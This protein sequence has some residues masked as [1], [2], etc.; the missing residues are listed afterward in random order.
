[1]SS[2][3]LAGPS[4]PLR[5]T[6]TEARRCVNWI[7]I[8]IESGTGKGGATTALKQLAGLT[9][10]GNYGAAIRALKVTRGRLFAVTDGQLSEVD[11][12]W[13]STP[14]GSIT[15][16]Q[17]EIDAN[18]T[19]V[20]IVNGDSLFVFDLDANTLS[21]NPPNW[22][23]SA[24][25]SVLDG[26]GLFFAPGTEQFYISAVEDFTS[27]DALDFATA[28]S[29]TGN[30][31]G[32]LAK[33][34]EV[35]ILKELGGE[36]WDD[37][38]GSDFPLSRNESAVIEIGLAA[39]ATLRKVASTAI[40]LGQDEDGNGIVFGMPGYVPQRISSQAL[41]EKLAALEDLSG[42]RAWT[43]H[44]EGLSFYV[45]NVPGLETTWCYEVS[46]GIWDERGEWLDGAWQPWRATCHALAFGQHVVGDAAGNLYRLDP[47]VNNNAGDPLVRDWISPHEAGPNL[48]VQRFGSFEV[49]GDVGYGL[50]DTTA[51]TLMLRYSDDGGRTWQDWRYLSLG[52]AGETKTRIRD[53]MLGSSDDRVW[54]FRVTDDVRCN[55]ISALVNER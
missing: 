45:L 41:E 32:T 33:H 3:P 52:A 46:A 55:V 15:A 25:I 29:T 2:L 39:R 38:G 11:A 37:A 6:Q 27:F 16:G 20:A 34:Q 44:Q 40:W 9:L 21:S 12:G 51:A 4:S 5:S 1:M 8:R 24:G 26:Y 54:N 47:L 22:R 10:L 48:Q 19:Q 53:T 36:V 43:Y 42:A 13:A 18:K 28:N 17:V 7:P 31:V 14:R 35:L 23:G 50:P 49:V 30:I